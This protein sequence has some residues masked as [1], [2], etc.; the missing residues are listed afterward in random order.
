MKISS[1]WL[2]P[3]LTALISCGCSKEHDNSKPFTSQEGEFSVCFPGKPKE[4]ISNADLKVLHRFYVES[5]GAAYFVLYGDVPEQRIKVGAETIYNEVRNGIPTTGGKLL[6]EKPITATGVL[7]RELIYV[8]KNEG[9]TYVQR[10]FLTKKRF[11]QVMVVLPVG[12][13]RKA[14]TD[15]VHFLDSFSFVNDK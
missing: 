10:L 6:A 13:E 12:N 1:V 5:E 11:Y 4:D 3:A 7:G 8:K 9:N 2:V 14:S 15:I